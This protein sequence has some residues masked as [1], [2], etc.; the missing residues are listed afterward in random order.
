MFILTFL[1]W[2]SLLF[3]TDLFF[4]LV[5]SVVYSQVSLPVSMQLE[6]APQH[7]LFMIGR[8]D[9]NIKQIMQR[10][11]ASVYFPEPNNVN[12]LRKGTVYITGPIESVYQARQHLIVSKNPAFIFSGFVHKVTGCIYVLLFKQEVMNSVMVII[13]RNRISNQGSN[14]RWSGLYFISC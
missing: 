8:G 5:K 1:V 10:T 2:S 11:G 14:P 7:H 4:W 12:P 13:V 9:M 3:F 6:I